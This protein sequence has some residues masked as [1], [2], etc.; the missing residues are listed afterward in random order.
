MCAEEDKKA[1]SFS[2]DI[3]LEASKSIPFPAA[4]REIAVAIRKDI[5]AKRKQKADIRDLLLNLYLWAVIEDFFNRIEWSNILDERILHSTARQFVKAI[6]A[7]Y[8]TIGYANLLVCMTN[9]HA[10]QSF[11]PILKKTDVKWLVEAFGEPDTHLTAR[12]ANPELWQ[13]AVEAFQDAAQ[14]DEEHFWRS[15]GFI[16]PP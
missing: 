10:I 13:Q 12:D 15:Q 7:P 4:F 8:K 1:E 6:K 14:R 5:R 2:K 16:I 9:G 11:V 3:I